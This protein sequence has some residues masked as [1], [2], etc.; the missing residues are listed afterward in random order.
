MEA[1]ILGL[2]P[3]PSSRPQAKPKSRDRSPHPCGLCEK[4]TSS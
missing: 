3:L 4:A 2:F 1:V